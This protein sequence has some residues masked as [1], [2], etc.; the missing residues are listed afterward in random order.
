MDNNY[1]NI[2]SS[3]INEFYLKDQLLNNGDMDNCSYCDKHSKCYSLRKISGI[4]DAT[5]ENHFIRTRENPTSYQYAML[6]DKEFCY[7]WERDGEQVHY[8]IMN[9]AQIPEKAALDIQAILNEKYFDI[10]MAQCGEE[11][12]FSG[13]SYYS[14]SSINS[15][16]W[17]SEWR[18]FKHSLN[19]ENRFFNATASNFLESVFSDISS[20]QTYNEHS[21]IVKVG[22][23]NEINELF[24]A[25]SF[26]SDDMLETALAYPEKELSPPPSA[27]ARAGRMNSDGISVFYGAS[28][29]E[30]A[31]AEVRPPVGAKVAVARFDIIKTLNLLDLRALE[32]IIP[33]GSIFNPVFS[34]QLERIH[35]LKKF[36]RRI[37]SPVMPD[38]EIY[39]YIPTQAIADYLATENTPRLDGIIFPS[40]QTVKNDFNIVLFHNSS[41]VEK[42][43]RQEDVEISV[44]SYTQYN[45]GSEIEYSVCEEIPT[46]RKRVDISINNVVYDPDS[47][48]PVLQIDLDSIQVHII[49]GVEYTA[50]KY[51]VSRR[52]L[53]KYKESD[54]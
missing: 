44:K 12:E 31:I 11:W 19:S 24:R 42:I 13:D 26:Q 1:K 33:V 23:D 54:F 6:S 10:E 15:E 27:L 8:A 16:N 39:E 9:A 30:T 40:V 46:Q 21:L 43:E 36:C 22:S 5:F 25:R 3:C 14:E 17:D 4:I 34:E 32:F 37:A 53:H 7:D 2:C 45:E 28:S 38:H 29:E 20:L 35:F 51:P 52:T 18:K 50:S 41:R 47:R 49:K 48:V